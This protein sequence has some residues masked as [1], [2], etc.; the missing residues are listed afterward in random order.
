MS[1]PLVGI[2]MGSESDR[3]TMEQASA[4]LERF[5]VPFEVSVMSAHRAPARVAEYARGAA[6]RGLKVLIGGAGLA[7]HLPGVMASYTALPVIGVPLA[8]PGLAGADALYSC[9]QMPPG[10]PVATVALGGAKNAAILAVQ[11]LSL[12][13]PGLVGKLARHKRALR[14]KVLQ[15]DRK[16]QAERRAGA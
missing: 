2:V 6:D 14:Q 7:A 15:G 16:V 5:G 9:V 3:P 1:Q 11:M 12:G 10:V 13:R 8:G 4:L